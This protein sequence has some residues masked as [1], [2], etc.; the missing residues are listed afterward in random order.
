MGQDDLQTANSVQGSAAAVS[1]EPPPA[2][3]A[4]LP[5]AAGEFFPNLMKIVCSW[6]N[7]DQGYKPGPAGKVTHTICRACLVVEIGEE[8]VMA[9]E[10]RCAS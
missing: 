5:P 6:C 2:A 10:A 4:A 7:T 3:P 9:M 1:A 8:R